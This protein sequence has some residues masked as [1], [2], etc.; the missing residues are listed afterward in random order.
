MQRDDTE[1]ATKADSPRC[2]GVVDGQG[3]MAAKE[4][5]KRYAGKPS[6]DPPKRRRGLQVWFQCHRC[7]LWFATDAGHVGNSRLA[8]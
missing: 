1:N 5:P 7:R 3:G 4:L 6:F 2:S 8:P